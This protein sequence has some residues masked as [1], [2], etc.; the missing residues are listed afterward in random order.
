ME[1]ENA[2]VSLLLFGCVSVVVFEARP[3][4]KKPKNL[5]KKIHLAGDFFRFKFVSSVFFCLSVEKVFFSVD[6][7]TLFNRII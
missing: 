2:A 5:A 6:T 4:Y 3:F 1:N 7:L